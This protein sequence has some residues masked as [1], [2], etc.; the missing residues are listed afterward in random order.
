LPWRLVELL[1]N[2]RQPLD[3]RW[4]VTVIIMFVGIM[5]Q[6]DRRERSSFFG[7]CVLSPALSKL[8]DQLCGTPN[9]ENTEPVAK[10]PDAYRNSVARFVTF[11]W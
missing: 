9:H 6:Y 10:C 11:A 1:P 7:V 5:L 4:G 2:R 8:R 3:V